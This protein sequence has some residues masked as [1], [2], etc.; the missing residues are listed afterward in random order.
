[1][2]AVIASFL[3]MSG[4]EILLNLAEPFLYA[5]I[6]YYLLRKL[7]DNRINNYALIAIALSYTLWF[8]LRPHELL[9]TSYHLWM[10]IFI[11][12]WTQCIV[13]F[14]YKGKYWRKII[15]WWYFGTISEICQA[16]AYVPILLIQAANGFYGEW[17]VVVSLTDT[18]VLLKSLHILSYLALFLY[19]GSMS[20]KIWRG[21]L[22]E[23]FQPFYLLLLLLPLGQKAALSLVVHPGMGDWVFGIMLAFIS[24]TELIYNILSLFGIGVCLVIDIAI[25]FYAL[26]HE[27]RA[28]IEAELNETKRVMELEQARFAEVE[29][30][31]EELAKIRH[32]LNNQLMSVIQLVRVGEDSAAKDM[33]DALAAEVN[34]GAE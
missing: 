24:D 27:K 31:G 13:I 9:G 25:L 23:K 21:I 10:N 3:E 18:N 8:I 26:S 22:M 11:N 4:P 33:L 19:I 1:M 2:G 20:V 30:R 16:V 6:H 17:S 34:R 15:V 7:L 5:Y 14:L 12:V 29:K 32:D 28:A